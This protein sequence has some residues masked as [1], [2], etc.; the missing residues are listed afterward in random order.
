M[1]IELVRI[2]TGDG[3]R[4]DGVVSREEEGSTP[5]VVICLHGVGSNF[6]GSSMMNRLA[7][8]LTDSQWDVLRVNTRGHD[9]C[10][11]GAYRLG[12]KRF[13]AGYEIVS[14]CVHDL[15][16]W[17][18]WAEQAEYKKII[19]LGHSLGA[20]KAV[21]RQTHVACDRVTALIAIS[22]PRLSCSIFQSGS[23]AHEF[24]ASLDAAEKLVESGNPEALVDVTFPFPLL[25]TAGSYV[26]KYGPAEKYDLV[27][28]VSRLN[29][30][31]H[32]IY[33]GSELEHGGVA[34]EGLDQRIVDCVKG[35]ET[36]K[37]VTLEVID[38]AD[39]L[40]TRHAD[41]L[42]SRVKETLTRW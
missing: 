10:Y 35:T 8:G 29:R 16:A 30:P 28:F 41:D 24:K 36:A 25:I 22:P 20:L 18:D 33:G 3:V 2:Q 7:I 27:G 12:T 38:N 31:T 23:R 32:F 37:R 13:G 21:Y 40:Y 15:A 26:D 6:Y 1:M 42:L 34:F 19:I 9:H 5:G 14:D 4:L 17:I 39:H 11:V